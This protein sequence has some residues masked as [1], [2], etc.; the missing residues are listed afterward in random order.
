MT[1][2]GRDAVKCFVLRGKQSIFSALISLHGLEA[3]LIIGFK[4]GHTYRPQTWASGICARESNPVVLV[5]RGDRY[6]SSLDQIGD[7]RN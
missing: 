4:V 5:H 3:R 1:D 7:P 6:A 2:G